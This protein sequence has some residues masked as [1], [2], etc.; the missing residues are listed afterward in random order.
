MAEN[1]ECE[2]W[3]DHILEL[4]KAGLEHGQ[5][6]RRAGTALAIVNM[7]V[8]QEDFAN[9]FETLGHDDLNLNEKLQNKNVHKKKYQDELFK[10]MQMKKRET[11]PWLIHT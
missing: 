3:M 4:V 8:Q 7:A 1:E 9:T 5:E 10:L 2:L 6:A 11:S